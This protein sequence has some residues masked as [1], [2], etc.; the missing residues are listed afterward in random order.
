[1]PGEGVALVHSGKVLLGIEG[2]N[3]DQIAGI[4]ITRKA[5]QAPLRQIAENAGVDGSVV[6]GKLL[7]SDSR[8]FGYDAQSESHGDL[9]KTGVIDP[10]K[11]VRIALEYGASIAGL[12]ITPKAMVTEKSAKSANNSMSEMAGMGD[13]V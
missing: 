13:M 9:L 11:V 8:A 10:T 1:M 6:A 7:E 2:E 12:L 3:T 5:I 4:T